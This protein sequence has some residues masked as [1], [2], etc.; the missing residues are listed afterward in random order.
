MIQ[1]KFFISLSFAFAVIIIG[2]DAL[3][4]TTLLEFTHKPEVALVASKPEVALLAS[5]SANRFKNLKMTYDSM[6][7]LQWPSALGKKQLNSIHLQKLG[8]KRLDSIY[9]KEL[10]MKRLDFSL[11]GTIAS[12]GE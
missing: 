7:E 11:N 2:N 1:T 3:P 10:G 12:Q 6:I 8:M 9:F 4:S 5:N